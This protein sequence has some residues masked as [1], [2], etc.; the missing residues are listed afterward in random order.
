[1]SGASRNAALTEAV[2]EWK[3]KYEI[4]EDDPMLASLELWQI[5]LSHSRP[6]ETATEYQELKKPLEQL[7]GLAN[8]LEKHCGEVIQ[9][10]RAVPKIRSELWAFPYFTV[11]L[12]SVAALVIGIF[13]G[14]FL[15]P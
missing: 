3:R 10:F 5:F 2:A 6:S 15:I 11:A 9:E 7:N 1:M 14:K 12:A 8:K 13:I 4:G